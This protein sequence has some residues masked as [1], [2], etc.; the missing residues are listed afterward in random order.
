MKQFSLI[1]LILILLSCNNKSTEDQVTQWIAENATPIESVEAGS[2]F[3]DLKSIGDMVQDARI[4]SLGEPTHGNR[5]VFQLK[6]RLIEYLV[7]EKGYNLFALECPFGEAFDVNQY[8]LEGIGTPEEALAGIYFWTWDTKEV[9]ELLKWMR[10]YN[11]DSSNKKKIKFYGFDIQDPERGARVMLEYLAKVNP[12]LEKKVR[13]ELGILEVAFSNPEISGRRQYIPEEYDS[14]SL[15]NIR[16]VMDSFDSNK[17]K[18]VQ[19]SSIDEW[20]FARQHARQVELWIEAC[21]NDGENYNN[22]RDL[23]QAQNLKWIMDQET[24]DSKMIIWAHN[25]HVSNFTIDGYEFMGSHMKNWYNEEIKIFG[26]FFNQGE[27]AA[28][29]V[30]NPSNGVNKFL[31]GPA[32]EKSVEIRIANSG[33]KLAALDLTKL[34]DNGFIH[35]WFNQEQPTRNSG[36]GYN[37]NDAEHYFVE[38]NLAE[39]FDALIY[40]DSTSAV[41]Y[42]NHSD[43]DISASIYKRLVGPSNMD[44]EDNNIGESPNDWVAW[45][46]F[47]RLGVNMIVTDDNPF[48]GQKSAM[49]QRSSSHR[50]GDITP[51]IRQYIDAKPY[52]GKRI[53]LRIAARA[54]LDTSSFAFARL[55]VDPSPL[56][57]AHSGLPP[58][59]D[60]LDKHRIDSE[61]WKIYEIEAQVDDNAGIIHYGIYLRDFGTVWMDDVAIEI[62][63]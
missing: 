49:L 28:R 34:P 45:S 40:V 61:D 42:V 47:K 35:D 53:R 39:A 6:H 62:I 26:I 59:F 24:T 51:S 9:V 44:F 52:R 23:G 54:E 4:V 8:L 58:F 16:L 2:G 41:K 57:D 15:Q 29:D 12:A 7:T 20:T 27:F 22:V 43:F 32:P 21:I 3:E 36:G 30:G 33:N 46:K 17:S 31:V 1:S 38:Y 10:N 63:E 11:A 55:C 5:E 56:S 18:Y 50:F 25:S 60:S 13:T 48:S 37:E 19:N 14:L